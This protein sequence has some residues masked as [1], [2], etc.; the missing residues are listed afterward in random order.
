MTEGEDKDSPKETRTF[1]LYSQPA[2]HK[3]IAGHFV[4]VLE[5]GEGWALAGALSGYHCP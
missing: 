4:G 2:F 5:P 1:A 3:R